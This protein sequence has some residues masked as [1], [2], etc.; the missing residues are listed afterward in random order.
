M[1]FQILYPFG[2]VLKSLIGGFSELGPI[3]M[4][5]IIHCLAV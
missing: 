1:N 2:N 4:Q 3:R 5:D